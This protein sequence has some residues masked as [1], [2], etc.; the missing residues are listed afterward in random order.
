M[1]NYKVTKQSIL[2]FV[3]IFLPIL[4]NITGYLTAYEIS[5]ISISL[6]FR[7]ILLIIAFTIS[8]KKGLH[9]FLYIYILLFIFLIPLFFQSI[10]NTNNF[11]L[12]NLN[13]VIKIIYPITIFY[14]VRVLYHKGLLSFSLFERCMKYSMYTYL[15]FILLAILIDYK[16][17]NY[18]I[19]SRGFMTS[20]N[21]LG[22]VMVLTVPFLF[23]N[24]KEK[25]RWEKLINVFCLFIVVLITTK[26]AFIA[27]GIGFIF[28]NKEL[29][30][31]SVKV[32]VTVNLL[33]LA[34]VSVFIIIYLEDITK[35]LDI[36][37]ALI[38]EN[39]FSF[40]FRGRNEILLLFNDLFENKYNTFEKIFGK[41]PYLYKL[42]LGNYFV[43]GSLL[44][45]EMD[46]PDLIGSFGFFGMTT[47]YSFYI[48]NFVFM[49][50][51]ITKDKKI[52]I[53]SY[54]MFFVH[55]F[56]AGHAIITA[57]VGTYSG[58][59][60]ALYSLKTTNN[61]RSINGIKEK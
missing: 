57:I 9:A 61:N 44:A 23:I 33:L 28:L 2:L 55:S 51:N 20:G 5:E 49:H 26:A 36:Y 18:G 48:I 21:D 11:I 19:G 31:K 45:V 27:F 30:D 29:W 47:I 42:E 32:F 40:L 12:I 38:D 16:V 52:I 54:L 34:I 41:S 58:S 60:L 8:I 3:F 50:K 17:R 35:V 4:D 24:F 46:P 6:Y 13:Y 22:L 39:I 10:V 43:P 53:L 59:I 15:F 25:A 56:F 7:I 37:K 14:A 1:N